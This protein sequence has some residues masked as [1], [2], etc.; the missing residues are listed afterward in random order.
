MKII[1]CFAAAAIV[2]LA[3]VAVSSCSGP[4]GY[5]NDKAKEFVKK[6][7]DDK[8]KK[9]DYAEMLEWYE[10][11]NDEWMEQWSDVLDERLSYWDY[12]FK[13]HEMGIEFANQYPYFNIV[14]A[15]LSAASEDDMGATTYKKYEKYQ[16]KINSKVEKYA[17]REPKDKKKNKANFDTATEEVEAAEEADIDNY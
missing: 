7:E 17:K 8:L 13:M 16:D 14:K 11:I 6:A 12:Q 9:A 10:A 3:A 4:A 15:M 1:K 5:S 2:L